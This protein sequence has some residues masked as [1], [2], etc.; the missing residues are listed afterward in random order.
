[1]RHR[2]NQKKPSVS[3]STKEKIQSAPKELLRRGLLSGAEKLQ[4]QLRNAAQ[5]GRQ[6]ETEADRAQG[7]VRSAAQEAVY[8]VGKLVRDRRKGKVKTYE[9]RCESS[10]EE[11]YDTHL[12][13]P[14]SAIETDPTVSQSDRESTR[15]KGRDSTHRSSSMDIG[16]AD[17]GKSEP[18]RVK[19]RDDY[20]QGKGEG[21]RFRKQKSPASDTV[22]SIHQSSQPVEQGRQKSVQKRQAAAVQQAKNQQRI[23][24][25]VT[26]QQG[27]KVDIPLR[28]T[29]T[30]SASQEINL[31]RGPCSRLSL[32]GNDKSKRP[33]RG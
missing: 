23:E 27:D 4:D 24:R 28:R 15:I 12:G 14:V 29:S 19:T 26:I 25:V 6:E 18:L 13:H 22:R 7:T 33:A 3:K 30:R 2:K 11:S 16:K 32:A 17:P 20:H 1:M 5:G 8:R 10:A 21:V 31:P 9:G